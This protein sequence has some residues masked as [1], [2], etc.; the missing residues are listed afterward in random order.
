M[1]QTLYRFGI[2]PSN[3]TTKTVT[4][5]PILTTA[6]ISICWAS[7]CDLIYRTHDS[8]DTQTINYIGTSLNASQQEQFTDPHG[9]L[10]AYFNTGHLSFFGSTMH[11]G[12]RGFVLAHSVG[13]FDTPAEEATLGVHY[14]GFGT[15]N[16]PSASLLPLAEVRICSDGS[17]LLACSNDAALLET[18][19]GLFEG[20]HLP[21]PV[22]ERTPNIGSVANIQG[23]KDYCHL[24]VGTDPVAPFFPKGLLVNATTQIALD[25]EGKVH[26]RTADPRYPACLGRPHTGTSAFEPVPYL[27]ETHITKIASG[28]YMTAAIS[29][30][31]ELFLW[32][33]S[34]PGTEGE[35]G[36]LARLD[37]W[38]DPAMEKETVIWGNTMQDEDIKCLNIS[39]DGEDAIAYDVAIGSGHILVAAKNDEEH[40]V[41]AAGCGREGQLGLGRTADFLEE[42]EEVVAL[43]GK[44][45]V[46]LE[47]VGWSSYAVTKP[48]DSR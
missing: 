18:E 30:D 15:Y 3:P 38:S 11:D 12:V 25:K 13:I 39:I 41:F 14:V 17:L 34:N 8:T 7:W 5:T 27:S 42:F 26:T 24:S 45:I 47:A 37:D 6:R 23:L 4:P 35:L 16:I 31:G 44:S 2:D 43:R 32:G 22:D 21:R 33:Q 28:G 20:M 36:V 29:E 10:S 40:V 46:Q 9:Y 1:T 19:S 48:E